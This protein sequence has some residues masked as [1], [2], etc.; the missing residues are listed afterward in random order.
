MRF[1]LGTPWIDL[2]GHVA[3]ITRGASGI[4]RAAATALAGSG[5][6]VLLLDRNCDGAEATA[7]AIR[8]PAQ[9]A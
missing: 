7:A 8:D 1:N 2:T 5:A 4:G 3:A 6:I 9:S